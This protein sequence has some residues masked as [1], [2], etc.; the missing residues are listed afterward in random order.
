MPE[1]DLSSLMQKLQGMEDRLIELEKLVQQPEIIQNNFLYSKHIK[2]HGNLNRVVTPF[3]ELKKIKNDA[4]SLKEMIASEKDFD[5]QQMMKEEIESLKKKEDEV[6][7]KIQEVLINDDEN[8]QKNAII[9]IRAGTGGDEASLFAG[10]LYE[11]YLKFAERKKWKCEVL[12]STPTNLGG[13][14]EVIFAIKGKEVYK[15]MK[16][17]SGGHRVQRIPS[18]EANGRIHTSACTVAVL[19]EAEEIE[20]DINP[21][22]LKIDTLRSSGPGGQNVNKTSSAVRITHIPS[23]IIVACQDT[24]EQYKNK[25]KAMRILRSK[26]LQ[27]YQDEQIKERNEIRKQQGTGDRSDRIRTY[28][29]PQNRVTDH[30]INMSIYNLQ[31]AMA[32]EI[33]EFVEN[34]QKH[35]RERL[36]Q[37]AMS[38]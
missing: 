34:L 1:T 8:D 5:I 38:K 4:E 9:E 24:P 31:A 23:G 36:I 11:M 18:T 14:K 35:E 21:K 37:E 10:D 2:E 32:G 13:Y 19:P 30:R 22:D 20:V 28:N 12:Y 15:M 7:Q 6:L 3:R 17:E 29:Y 25:M 26:L 27:K 16:F 33:D